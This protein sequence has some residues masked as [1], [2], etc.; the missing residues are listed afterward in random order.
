MGLVTGSGGGRFCRR[1]RLKKRKNNRARTAATA[2]PRPT[3]RPI[4]RP[5]EELPLPLSEA[6]TDVDEGDGLDW[7][8]AVASSVVDEVASGLEALDSEVVVSAS[9]EEGSVDDVV[10]RTVLRVSVKVLA[11]MTVTVVAGSDPNLT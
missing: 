10:G 2:T 3:P 5:L 9:E 1:R 6:D 4:A 7:L 8:S 11:P